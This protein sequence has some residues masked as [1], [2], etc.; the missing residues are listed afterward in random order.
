M[1][2]AGHPVCVQQP[3]AQVAHV[4]LVLVG[5]F[6]PARTPW[7]VPVAARAGLAVLAGTDSLVHLMATS[8][9]ASGSLPSYDSMDWRSSRLCSLCLLLMPPPPLAAPASAAR[10]LPPRPTLSGTTFLAPSA[11]TR[12]RRRRH[13]F[14][15]SLSALAAPYFPR[16]PA[17]CPR[18][19]LL[20]PTNLSQPQRP[21]RA[22]RGA[23]AARRPRRCGA[24]RA[25]KPNSGRRE[26]RTQ[27]HAGKTHSRRRSNIQ[28]YNPTYPKTSK[29]Y[30]GAKRSQARAAPPM[31]FDTR[32]WRLTGER[33]LTVRGWFRSGGA[34][35]SRFVCIN[36][37]RGEIFWFVCKIDSVKVVKCNVKGTQRF[38]EMKGSMHGFNGIPFAPPSVLVKP[39]ARP[40]HARRAAPLGSRAI[41]NPSEGFHLVGC[42]FHNVMGVFI[43]YVAGAA[44]YP[45]ARPPAAGM[46]VKVDGGAGGGWWAAWVG[47][48]TRAHTAGAGMDGVGAR[49]WGWG[50]G[51]GPGGEG[52]GCAR[53]AR[54]G[55]C[56]CRVRRRRGRCGLG[57]RTRAT[58]PPP[59][60]RAGAR[61]R[62][63]RHARAARAG[64]GSR[65]GL[66][67]AGGRPPRAR[68]VGAG[69]RRRGARA[70]SRSRRA[71]CFGFFAPPGRSRFPPALRACARLGTAQLPQR[72]VRPAALLAVPAQP[73]RPAR[74]GAASAAGAA[75]RR[76]RRA[77]GGR[78]SGHVR[79][80]CLCHA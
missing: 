41:S 47:V 22:A 53:A 75:R 42:G 13:A 20:L 77:S 73:A 37:N 40:S 46:A 21:P 69:A 10:P 17:L 36:N 45:R 8:H 25:R 48:R 12:R 52:G 4:L 19:L 68:G 15:S 14:L 26:P 72:R 61:A 65:T 66:S 16:P 43:Y 39:H 2:L 34:P 24:R 30:L 51:G 70:A 7:C 5:V 38:A 64:G 27:T 55:A 79:R 33:V 49:G 11:P 35:E 31:A 80:P 63:A 78:R 71:S 23:H 58:R 56:C 32:R 76:A 54:G 60:A 29:P 3:H 50:G 28:F 62:G 67:P 44:A 59:R 57:R 74:L 1:S 9:G 6:R 18:L